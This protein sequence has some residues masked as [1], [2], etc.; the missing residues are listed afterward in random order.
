M[1]LTAPQ[2]RSQALEE[3][4]Q[5]EPCMPDTAGA[6]FLVG[7]LY[8]RYE[9]WEQAAA[10]F[11]RCV[12]LAPEAHRSWHR[13]GIT[14]FNIG[15][16]DNGA[17]ALRRAI[18]LAPENPDY[19]I[20]LSMVLSRQGAFQEAAC[21]ARSALELRPGDAS[22]LNNLGHAFQCMNRSGE[23]LACYD[24]ATQIDPGNA[25][26]RFGRATAF[27]RAGQFREGWAEYEWRWGACQM[28]RLDLAVPLWEG[29]SLR[30]KTIFVHH[31]QGY[32]DTLQ[33]VRLVR[34]L[35]GKGAKVTLQ[36]PLPLK[37][38]ME[39]VQGVTEVTATRESFL[40]PNYHVPLLS[41]PLR[42]KIDPSRLSSLPYLSAPLE[43]QVRQGGA[44][45]QALTAGQAR[46][47][48]TVGLVWGGDP[49]PHDQ[50]AFQTDRRR[51]VVLSRL[52]PLFAVDGVRFASFQMGA[53]R[54]QIAETGFPLYDATDGITD[55][56]DTA[57]RLYGV[58]LLISVDT[59][60]VHLAGGLGRPVWML[61]RADAC[62]RWGERQT[63]TP[64][65]PTMRIFHQ[66]VSGDWE[67]V[68]VDAAEMLRKLVA[69]YRAHQETEAA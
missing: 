17:D 48:L 42:L 27:L 60:M 64:W 13:L 28:P 21:L 34:M 37:R 52:A 57:A 54:H 55:F 18:A 30:G 9:A 35:A 24:Q 39:R 38:L 41:L 20:D 67:S 69:I 23:A 22:A 47:D 11:S 46:P 44:L 45:R 29:Q 19:R 65:Y 33:F 68:A 6:T 56:A 63:L 12:V 61:S 58:D 3:L 8:E 40:K 32:G 51:S 5:T 2:Q 59:S 1:S 43:E 53:P 49:R 16:L 31:E 25:T 66:P 62:W 14:L 7:G 4:L 36:V 10:F 15:D 50:R 26:V